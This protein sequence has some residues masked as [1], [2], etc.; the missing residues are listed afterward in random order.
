MSTMFIEL[1]KSKRENRDTS[2]ATIS[3]DIK[4]TR[5]TSSLVC[6]WVPGRGK[7]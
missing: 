2:E 5:D 4:F 3:N 1:V 7:Q 6:E